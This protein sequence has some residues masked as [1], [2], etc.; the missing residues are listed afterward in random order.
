MSQGI[1]LSH[2]AL[3]YK[4][5]FVPT[6]QSV[7]FANRRPWFDP[8]RV[9]MTCIFFSQ[10]K[11]TFY[12]GNAGTYIYLFIYVYIYTYPRFCNQTPFD[13]QKKGW[14]NIPKFMTKSIRL[15]QYLVSKAREK[16]RRCWQAGT[17][18]QQ[19]KCM[20]GPRRFV[21][22]AVKL[23]KLSVILIT[24]TDVPKSFWEDFLYAFYLLIY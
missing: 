1:G 8:S 21:T 13:S 22:I 17:D 5:A 24:C 12:E 3:Q 16:K 14:A 2:T 6:R 9:M 15:H 20:R 23:F 11:M 4:V 10:S 7:W 19:R 18:T